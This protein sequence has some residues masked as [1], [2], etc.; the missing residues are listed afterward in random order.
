MMKVKL[1]LKK[2]DYYSNEAYNTLRTNI[3]FCGGDKRVIEFTSCM[4]NE[5]KSSVTLNLAVSMAESGKSVLLIDADL[6]KSVLKARV[7]L[8]ERVDGLTHYLTG[9]ASVEEIICTTDIPQ[10][11]MIFAGPVPPNPSELL[12]SSLFEE[13]ISEQRK[14]YEYIIIDTPPLG[15]VIDSA[16]IARVCDGTIM[17]V[18]TD[19]VSYKLAQ[20]VKEQMIK[21]GCPILGVVLNKVDI[22]KRSYYGKYKKYRKYKEY[23]N[24][25]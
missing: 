15:S 7:R 19:A 8:Q 12:N 21:T 11:H 4:P 9:Q 16:I 23:K 1:A 14:K 22:S 13:L 18:E 6:R 5:G 24:R 17:V 10:L 3:Q 20:E 2:L 25:G